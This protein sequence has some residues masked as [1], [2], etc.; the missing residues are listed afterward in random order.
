MS[1][2]AGGTGAAEAS[3][4]LSR[5]TIVALVA[6]GL[7]VFVIANDFTA[8]SVAI[9]D[10]E[11]DFDTTLNR[12]QWV[13]NGYALV[14]GVL[15]VTAGRLADLFGRRRLFMIG[16][17]L[18]AGFSLLG[19]L[20]P[21]IET[22]IAFRALMGVGGAMMW[23]AIL[24]MTYAIL[25]EDKA[26]LAGGMIIGVAGVG[27][28][29]GPLLGGVLTDGLSWRW[30]FFINL[31][32]A[33]VAMVATHRFVGET[34][35]EGAER[36]IDYW[37][38]TALTVGVIAI[39]LAL[40]QGTESGFGQPEIIAMFAVGGLALVVFALIERS[41]GAKALV[42]RDVFGNVE[43]RAAC[44]AVLAMSAIFFAAILYLPQFMQK[45]L[46]FSPLGSGAGML[47]MM[48]V[49][50][51]TSFVAGSL[52]NR[53][54]PKL[55]VTTGALLLGAGMLTLS[56]LDAG[57]S[58]ASLVPGMVVLGAGVGLFYSSITTA[59]VTALDP[60]R[61]SLAGGIV[62]MCQI[63]GGS[64][65]LGINTAIV[66]GADSLPDGITVAFRVD[67]ALAMVGVVIA[68]L[69]IGG[70]DALGR[71]RSHHPLRHHHRAHA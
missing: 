15:I 19:G 53:L 45:E 59:G 25:P 30:I 60:S 44:L 35:D 38:V 70:T 6:M 43:F 55:V 47:P 7:G 36:K 50:A 2:E 31:P 28:A 26:G 8:L 10:I 61:S 65:G 39:L 9:P 42:P 22:L 23:P 71:L 14:F 4:G 49:F 20:A 5:G 51:L 66:L 40:D 3:T 32:I 69:Y 33:I 67:A 27:N 52:Y 34:R 48:V 63:A 17:T 46:D 58:W 12:A 41:A 16:A 13:I 56:F 57:S 29:F 54:G 68:L 62:Y 11:S 18:F 1:A 24:G 21:N 37:G 64:L